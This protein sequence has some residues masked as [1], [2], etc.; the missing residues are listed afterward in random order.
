MAASTRFYYTANR[1]LHP[2]CICCYADK[3]PADPNH[4]D[5]GQRP[6]L[7]FGPSHPEPADV[8]RF[9]CPAKLWLSPMLPLQSLGGHSLLPLLGFDS[10]LGKICRLP[11]TELTT[12]GEFVCCPRQPMDYLVA[13]SLPCAD[14]LTAFDTEQQAQICTNICG[15]IGFGVRP[16]KAYPCQYCDP[17]WHLLRIKDP[18]GM[19]TQ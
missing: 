13:K 10:R 6:G 11:Q 18:Q 16:Q 2:Y 8:P 1:G 12:Y 9:A 3:R 5:K 7:K 14:K 15:S 4:F 19:I 17:A